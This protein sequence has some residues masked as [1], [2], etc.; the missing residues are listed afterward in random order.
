[1]WDRH[2]V[3]PFPRPHDAVRV[4]SPPHHN[5]AS[6]HHQ[7]LE[8]WA[9]VFRAGGRL[10]ITCEDVHAYATDSMGFLTCTEV[11]DSGTATGRLACTNIFEKQGDQWRMVHHCASPEPRM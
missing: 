2:I 4:R 5:D 10:R 7:V 8:S 6:S 1:M 9:L 3:W 11:V